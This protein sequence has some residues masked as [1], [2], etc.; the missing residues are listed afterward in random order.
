MWAADLSQKPDRQEAEQ[1]GIVGLAVEPR[2]ANV[3]EVPQLTL[4]GVQGPGGEPYINQNDIRAA[5]N[6]PAAKVDLGENGEKGWKKGNNYF[7]S[8]FHTS[9]M[10]ENVFSLVTM[11]TLKQWDF[12]FLYDATYFKYYFI[13]N[14]YANTAVCIIHADE[15]MF[16]YVATEDL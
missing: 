6:E 3:T 10:S 4:P 13:F 16:L 8:L 1:H 9:P 7:R 15:V 11:D 12:N 14:P 5:L 2:H